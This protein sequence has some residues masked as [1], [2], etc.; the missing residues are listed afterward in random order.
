M[1]VSQIASRSINMNEWCQQ[2]ILTMKYIQ[3]I[4]QFIFYFVHNCKQKLQSFTLSLNRVYLRVC[5]RNETKE[6]TIIM[7]TRK[8]QLSQVVKEEVELSKP[9]T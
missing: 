4:K 9:W 7:V 8:P 2:V 1:Q 3:T 5:A 6:I